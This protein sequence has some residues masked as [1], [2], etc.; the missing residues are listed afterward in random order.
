MT[1]MKVC[2]MSELEPGTVR[3]FDGGAEAIAVFN[4]EGRYYATQDRCPHGNWPLSDSYI[5]GDTIECALHN[6]CFSIRTGKRLG[7]PVSR[8]L[9]TYAV[10]IQDDAVL[11]DIDSGAFE[12]REGASGGVAGSD[13]GARHGLG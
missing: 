13:E 8:P 11:V 5:K 1:L 3:R 7:P 2:N 6:G 10:A 9:R 12:A 4:I